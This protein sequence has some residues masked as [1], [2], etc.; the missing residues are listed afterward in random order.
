MEH[1]QNLFVGPAVQRPGQGSGS[2]CGREV[3]IGL[4][5]AHRSHGA[6]A[7]VLPVV[8]VQDQEN[9]QGAGEYRIGH[10]LRPHH[11]HNVFMK[12]SG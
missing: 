11:L 4:S 3:G 5:A 7:A 12:F 9:V 10:V 8:G 1:V 6:G 2:G